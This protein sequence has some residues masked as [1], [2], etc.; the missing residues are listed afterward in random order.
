MGRRFNPP[1]LRE[2]IMRFKK[3]LKFPPLNFSK[4]QPAFLYSSPLKRCLQTANVLKTELDLKQKVAVTGGFDETDYGLLSGKTLEQI[5]SEQPTF[6]KL[7]LTK[8]S[9]VQFPNGES[10]SQV[11]KRSYQKLLEI[12]KIL[13]GEGCLFIVTHVDIIKMIVCQLLRIPIDKKAFFRIDNGSI[14]CLESYHG[15][16]RVKFLNI[17]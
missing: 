6:Y 12:I 10:Y 14:T 8:P 4:D 1:I 7:W 15:K 3:T 13:P 2:E 11:Q 5:K 16:L 9:H 17:S